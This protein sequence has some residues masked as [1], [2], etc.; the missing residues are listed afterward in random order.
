MGSLE[1]LCMLHTS[2]L[3]QPDYWFQQCLN[4]LG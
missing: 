3:L 2:P 1:A 4:Y